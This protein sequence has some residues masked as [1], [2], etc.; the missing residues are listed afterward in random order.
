MKKERVFLRV[1]V[2]FLAI[3]LLGFA[4]FSYGQIPPVKPGIAIWKITKLIAKPSCYKKPE[5]GSPDFIYTIKAEFVASPS[6]LPPGDLI[7]EAK[8]V[9]NYET[10]T[11]PPLNISSATKTWTPG[12]SGDILWN[13][14]K[15]RITKVNNWYFRLTKP[16]CHISHKVD[17]VTPVKITL[18]AHTYFGPGAGKTKIDIKTL[19]INPCK[20]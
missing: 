15:I 5:P 1:L 2:M 9:S 11:K 10:T 3:A 17:G 7:I 13:G 20:K 14:D 16:D 18:M 6:T 19:L 12:T 4:Q 8:Y